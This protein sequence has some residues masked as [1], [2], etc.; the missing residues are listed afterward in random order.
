MHPHVADRARPEVPAAAPFERHVCRVVGTKWRRS[1]PRIPIERF[2]NRRRIR[3]SL[4][5]LRP[6]AD[7]SIGPHVQLMHVADRAA[8]DH[9]YGPTAAFH[10]VALL[11]HLR[12][13]AGFL[14]DLAHS[15]GFINRSR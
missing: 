8:A 1:Q 13:H 11:T 12:H 4:F 14:R 2:R 3:G 9:F 6:P 5:A 7:R 10:R 15:P